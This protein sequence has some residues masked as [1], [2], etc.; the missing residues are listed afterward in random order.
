MKFIIFN[1][2]VSTIYVKI[3]EIIEKLNKL[4]TKLKIHSERLDG[5]T[6]ELS[7]LKSIDIEYNENTKNHYLNIKDII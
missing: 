3:K 2:F 5:L 6:G 4:N 7:N 1:N